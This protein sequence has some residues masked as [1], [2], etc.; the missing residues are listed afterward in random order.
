MLPDLD[1]L[2]LEL[3]VEECNSSSSWEVFGLDEK[4][5]IMTILRYDGVHLNRSVERRVRELNLSGGQ[6]ATKRTNSI[7]LSFFIKDIHDYRGTS[8][9]WYGNQHHQP[10]SPP[11]PSS[12]Y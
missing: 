1:L 3:A 9:R 7:Q 8:S 12:M 11:S 10:T 6:N 4:P 5:D 2:T